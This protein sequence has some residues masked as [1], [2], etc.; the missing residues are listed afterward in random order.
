M[1]G[2]SLDYGYFKVEQ[3]ADEIETGYVEKKFT[4]EEEDWSSYYTPKPMH[5]VDM[6]EGATPEQR[7]AIMAEAQDLLQTLRLAAKRAKEL[8]WFTSGDT[9]VDSYLERLDKI[10]NNSL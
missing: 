3:L 7:A 4:Y 5:T 6:L 1:S 10:K 2:G 8:E 9:G